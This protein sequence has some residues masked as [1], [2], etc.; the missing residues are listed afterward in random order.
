MWVDEPVDLFTRV[1]S[2][3]SDDTPKTS[4]QAYCRVVSSYWF[5]GTANVYKFCNIMHRDWSNSE[6]LF[7]VVCTYQGLMTL[8]LNRLRTM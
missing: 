4:Q 6:K 7:D 5:H 2:V 8:D 3:Y 1:V